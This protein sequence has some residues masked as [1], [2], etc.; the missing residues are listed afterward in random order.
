MGRSKKDKITAMLFVLPALL[1][2]LILIAYPLIS[3]L[4]DSFQ[5]KH[6]VNKGISGFVGLDNFK[7]VLQNEHFMGNLWNTFVWTIFSVIGEYFLGITSALALN[8]KVR[9]RGIFRGLIIIPW[10]VPI[11]VAGMTWTWM[12]SP[13]YGIINYVLVKLGLLDK[14]YY[15]LGE[16][17]TALMAVTFVNIWRS[18]PYYTI[19]ILAALQAVP[20]D[21][22]EAARIDGTNVI[23]RFFKV[24][25]PQLKSI[26]FV[27]VFVHIISTAI[28]FD[29]IWVMTEGGPNYASETLP[30][31]IYRYAM[32]QFNVGAA[33][34]LASMMMGVMFVGFVVYYYKVL[35]KQE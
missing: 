19:S 24:I 31:M 6:L 14:G 20:G 27:L 7:T 17:N 16:T 11:V 33:S 34:S 22:I 29:F 9:F 10:I 18:F 12:L 4:L 15:W 28:N 32:K 35:K 13:D 26:S 1:F 3:V 25:L 2:L 8:Q 30:L 21:M 23:Q 5:A